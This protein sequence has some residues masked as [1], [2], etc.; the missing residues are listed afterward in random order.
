MFWASS[1][2]VNSTDVS[3]S[4]SHPNGM[5]SQWLSQGERFSRCTPVCHCCHCSVIDVGDCLWCITWNESSLTQSKQYVGFRCVRGCMVT[6]KPLNQ[7]THACTVDSDGQSID[8]TLRTVR[9]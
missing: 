7:Q 2:S 9:W 1:N 6:E 4:V 3:S 8:R 5:T